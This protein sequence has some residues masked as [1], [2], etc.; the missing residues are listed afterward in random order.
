MGVC[1]LCYDLAPEDHWADAA[2]PGGSGGAA[3]SARHRRKRLLA[4]VLA[5]YGLTVSDPGTGPHWV[6]GNRKGAED[7][8][9]GL[10][11]IWQAADRL[12][13]RPIDVLDPRLLEALRR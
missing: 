12:S 10:P 3:R 1:V 7:V 2:P 13:S 4:A 11:A 8:A 9:V 6:I 5:P